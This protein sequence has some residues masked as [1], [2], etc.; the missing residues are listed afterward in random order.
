M[1]KLTFLLITYSLVLNAQHP[2]DD[3]VREGGNAFYNYEYERSIEILT[4]AREDYPDHPGVHIAWAAA[5][6]RKDEAELSLDEIYTNFDKNLEDVE[7]VYD[8]LLS[9]YPENPEYM[10]YYGCALGLK[11]RTLLGQKK[12]IST[13]FSAYRG[14]RVI[15][16]AA[17]MD[18]TMLD[19]Y[20]PIGIVEYYTGLSNT[21]VKA[22]A[23]Y[24]GLEAS[25]KEGL[26]KMEISASQSPWAWTESLSVLSYIYQFI[27]LDIER[28]LEISEQLVEKFPNNYDYKI[29]Y[30]VS[31]LQTGDL[32][33]SK[34]ILD[35]LDRTLYMQRARHQEG[36]GSYLDY[37]WG[38]YY[39]LI[40]DD[41]KSLEK[42]DECINNYAAE[43]DAFLGEAYFLKAKIMDKR[44]E[45][46][47]ARKYYRKCIRLD[48]F[49][50]V[51]ILSKEYLKDPFEG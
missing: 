45:R 40:G 17:S 49:S 22:G 15:Q 16:K 28:G 29:H 31:L 14:F 32:K 42:L 44:G 13:F 38:Y 4:K 25:R 11:A 7:S 43:L 23:E 6:W 9:I 2:G 41:E 10:L 35:D 20:L 39:Y 30:G 12:W 18:T 19:A 33:T 26:R 27:D 21:L 5:H 46:V 36:F 50:H 34:I 48:N 3:V 37:L 51:I 8:S 1:M 24:F 47:K